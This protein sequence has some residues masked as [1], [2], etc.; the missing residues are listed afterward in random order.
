MECVGKEASGIE[1]EGSLER[2]SL[3]S[4]GDREDLVVDAGEALCS[5]RRCRESLMFCDAGGLNC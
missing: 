4:R 2:R 1:P 5:T 3:D